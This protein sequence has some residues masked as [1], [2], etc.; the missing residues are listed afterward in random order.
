[1]EPWPSSS[2]VN[3]SRLL[4]LLKKFMVLW[5]LSYKS[6]NILVLEYTPNVIEPSFGIG[7]IMYSLF[8]H[9][10]WIREGDENRHVL[11]FPPCIA[12]FK[13]LLLPLSGNAE[14]A[15]IVQQIS[16]RLRDLG[17][18]HKVDDSTASIG[19]RYSRNDELGTPF[20]MTVDFQSVQDSTVTLRERDSTKQIREPIEVV[21]TVLQQLIDEKTTW[22]DVLSKYRVFTQQEVW[23]YRCSE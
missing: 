19:K 21:V 17:I 5:L 1:M 13:C 3:W 23:N 22:D 12:P 2:T 8:E 16:K 10:W 18:S 11:S 9:V 6:N 20:G 14:F 4:K 15:P 7:R